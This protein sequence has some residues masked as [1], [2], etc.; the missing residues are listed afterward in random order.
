M[1]F[2]ISILMLLISDNLISENLIININEV[3]AES[4][5]VKEFEK[6][7]SSLYGEVSNNEIIY[8]SEQKNLKVILIKQEKFTHFTVQFERKTVS[9]DIVGQVSYVRWRPQYKAFI[10]SI[11]DENSAGDFGTSSLYYTTIQVDSNRLKYSI[12]E[13]WK[14]QI[15][16]DFGW[17]PNGLY[18]VYT[19][20]SNLR[21]KNFES[22]VEWSIK[23]IIIDER[24]II[25]EDQSKLFQCFIWS[26]DSKYLYFNW[27]DTPFNDKISGVVKINLNQI[28]L[29]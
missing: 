25:K 19:K 13:I 24:I 1:K 29:Y 6:M 2:L 8:N 26:Y 11:F 4:C 21:I 22:N 3:K 23:K 7:S 10:Y 9:F 12:K 27:K 20:A 18:C 16:T 28:N 5:D 17:S 15:D 14:N